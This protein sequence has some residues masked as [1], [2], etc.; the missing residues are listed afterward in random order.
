MKRFRSLASLVR[1]PGACCLFPNPLG[2]AIGSLLYLYGG[3]INLLDDI[4]TMDEYKCYG[5]NCSAKGVNDAK[6]PIILKASSP[7]LNFAVLPL[8]PQPNLPCFLYY[9][10][11][12][13][14]M[15]QP[16]CCSYT[17]AVSTFVIKQSRVPD[18]LANLSPLPEYML[19]IIEDVGLPLTQGFCGDENVLGLGITIFHFCV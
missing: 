4:N 3:L 18:A 17:L 9:Y 15:H 7:R 6:R 5:V 19:I 10:Y 11:L 16:H 13:C 14:G 2:M 1:P 8:N 12:P